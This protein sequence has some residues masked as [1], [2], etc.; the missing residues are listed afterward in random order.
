MWAALF[1]RRDGIRAR[2]PGRQ[3]PR[4]VEWCWYTQRIGFSNGTAEHPDGGNLIGNGYSWTAESCSGG[5]VCAGG[6]GGIFGDG[7]NGYNG[8]NGG[9]AGWFERWQWWWRGKPRGLMVV[10]VA[11]AAVGRQWGNGGVGGKGRT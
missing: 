9:S 11:R 6:D 4:I 1:A 10:L 5:Q 7:G 2:S 8:G 3:R